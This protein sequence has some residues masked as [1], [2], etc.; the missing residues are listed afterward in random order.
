MYVLFQFQNS[1]RKLATVVLALRKVSPAHVEL[2][3]YSFPLPVHPPEQ[4]RNASCLRT[5]P[6]Q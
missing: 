5:D 3:L 2:L 4:N 1:L 6:R